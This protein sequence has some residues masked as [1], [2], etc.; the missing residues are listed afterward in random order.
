MPLPLLL[1]IPVICAASAGAGTTITVSVSAA[2]AAAA[3]TAAAAGAGAATTISAAAA[4]AI[5][6][7]AGAGGVAVGAGSWWAWGFFSKPNA[8]LTQTHQDSLAAQNRMTEERIRGASDAVELLA[9]EAAA[10]KLEVR[11]AVS[12]TTVSTDRLQQLSQRISETNGR[13]VAAVESARETSRTLAD[14]LPG[15]REV[16]ESSNLQGIAAVT[17]LSELN[18]LLTLKV[19]TLIQTASDIGALQHTVD[20]QTTVIT[21]LGNAVETLT[22]ENEAQGR[23]IVQ[24]EREVTQLKALSTR[25]GEQ[26]RFFRQQLS[27]QPSLPIHTPTVAQLS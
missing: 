14:S 3:A 27:Q 6:V 21:R 13:L 23:V 8:K 26:C 11:E 7:G 16:S 20:E 19:D 5:G 25:L 4:T 17:M 12:A 15:L 1:A 18:E 10:L 24:K 9:Q 22:A 2:A